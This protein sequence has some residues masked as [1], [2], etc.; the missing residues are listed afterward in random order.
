MPIV[1]DLDDYDALAPNSSR[2]LTKLAAVAYPD[3]ETPLLLLLVVAERHLAGALQEHLVA[4]GFV[5]HRLVHHNVMAHITRD[6]IRLTEL[7][8]RAGMTK[9]AMSELVLDLEELGYLRREPDPT[10]GRAKLIRL[11]KK[12]LAAV[13]AATLA[14]RKMDTALDDRLPKDS[15]RALRR[16]LRVA[17]D[18]RLGP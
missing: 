12:G 4:A 1:R 6:G 10:D 16:G 15:L 2:C 18:T 17:L 7:A 8:E 5:D 13:S 14:L 11:T 9:Q 3:D